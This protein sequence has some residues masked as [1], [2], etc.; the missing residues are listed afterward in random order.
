MLTVSD[1]VKR[2]AI[3]GFILFHIAVIASFSIPSGTEFAG[4]IGKSLEHYAQRTGLFQN[5][6]MFAPNPKND[7]CYVEAE[8]TFR[9][10]QKRLWT[11]PQM[12]DL[13]YLE[14]YSKER[15]RKFANERLQL[16]T[17]SVLLPD[18]ARYIARLNADASN[19][20]Q[21][22]KLVYHWSVIPPP[23]LQGETPQT[24][25]WEHRVLFTYSVKP[26]DLR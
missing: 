9:N 15:Y 26:G 12:N 21:S 7:N 2:R 3:S 19:P 25:Q 5:W 18:A 23:P 13:G 22:V 14:R 8:I 16:T 4:V 11:F 20:P 17:N 1:D 10:G 6:A 24:G